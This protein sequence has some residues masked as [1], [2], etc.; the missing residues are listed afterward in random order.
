MQEVLPFSL[1]DLADP[2]P[3]LDKAGQKEKGS[4]HGYNMGC[5]RAFTITVLQRQMLCTGRLP[6]GL[7]NGHGMED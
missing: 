2:F 7:A 1:M 5:M 4:Y 6:G 3:K